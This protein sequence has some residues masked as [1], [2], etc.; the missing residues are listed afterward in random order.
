MP[1][2]IDGNNL[3]FA[4]RDADPERP[5]GRS[6][7]GQILASWSLCTREPVHIVFDGPAPASALAEQ[8]VGDTIRVSFSGAGVPADDVVIREINASTA[9]RRLIVVSSD[10]VVALSARRR[11]CIAMRSDDF[12]QQVLADLSR[13]RPRPLP[14]Q[15]LHGLSREESDRWAKEFGLG[16]EKPA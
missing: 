15:R 4:A 13:P 12:W 8:I 3:L 9:P 16:D 2:L 10:R 6:R 11:R 5:V 1:V 14:P 7:L